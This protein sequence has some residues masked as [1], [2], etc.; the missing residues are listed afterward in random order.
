MNGAYKQW[1]EL[2]AIARAGQMPVDVVR[3]Q[4]AK[5]IPRVETEKAPYAAEIMVDG[6]AVVS[7]EL[8]RVEMNLEAGKPM[9]LEVRIGAARDDEKV[10]RGRV[11]R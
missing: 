5:E 8:A 6:E 2:E 3:R 9:E 4:L 11:E 1:L 10:P 7:G